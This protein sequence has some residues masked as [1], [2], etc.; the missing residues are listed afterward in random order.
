MRR[1]KGMWW[2]IRS[3]DW[4]LCPIW[5]QQSVKWRRTVVLI[6]YPVPFLSP[7]LL[8]PGQMSVLLAPT[9]LGA[10]LPGHHHVLRDCQL[11]TGHVHGPWRDSERWAR[12]NR[13]QLPILIGCC[14]W[15][16]HRQMRTERTSSGRRC[17]RTPTS[18]GSRCA[19][20]GVSPASFTGRPAAPIAPSAITASR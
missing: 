9:A 11:H 13:S 8:F 19:W 3:W 12:L 16:Q 2:A 17:T 1:D 14:S 7:I 15:L 20:S 10:R 5:G 18:T 4:D 6:S